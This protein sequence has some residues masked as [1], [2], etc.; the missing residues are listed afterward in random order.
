MHVDPHNTSAWNTSLQGRKRWI[1][2]HPEA[3]K[4]IVTG[5]K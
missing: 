2:V 4:K 1:F 3:D 5:R